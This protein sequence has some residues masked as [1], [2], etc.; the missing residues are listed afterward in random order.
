MPTYFAYGSNMNPER[1]A[2]RCPEAAPVGIGWLAKHA[3]AINERGVATMTPRDFGIVEGVLWSVTDDCLEALDR[4]EGVAGGYYRREPVTV[5]T[6]T[7][8]VD[9]VTYVADLQS[10]AQPRPGYLEKILEGA[11]HFGLG[12]AHRLRLRRLG[13][14]P[15][16]PQSHRAGGE[17]DAGS[18]R[19][20]VRRELARVAELVAA[21]S[22][23]TSKYWT[24]ADVAILP[25]AP[26]ESAGGWSSD[27]V[28][29]TEAAGE[30]SWLFVLLRDV[31]SP[32]ASYDH[33]TKLE[34][35]AR[36]AD[37][38]IR[39]QRAGSE[40]TRQRLFDAVVTEAF[41]IAEAM[42]DGD[43]PRSPA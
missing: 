30:L 1:M 42:C 5:Q 19:D 7:G 21:G 36:L 22:V 33:L 24:G 17:G 27:V 39:A 15:G 23:G 25:E 41:A 31:F 4:Y 43:R 11:E 28:V 26:A 34:V 10:R 16:A 14:T 37:A 8:D 18:D 12:R 9:A 6:T 29:V 40:P 13:S 2:E 32:A 38:A 20:A 3:V 35:F